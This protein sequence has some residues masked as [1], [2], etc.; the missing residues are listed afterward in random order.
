MASTGFCA[1]LPAQF[2]ID[3][4]HVYQDPEDPIQTL[5]CNPEGFPTAKYIEGN[6][7]NY[8]RMLG[9]IIDSEP[10]KKIVTG[11]SSCSS[12]KDCGNTTGI[13]QSGV[14]KCLPGWTGPKCL[15]PTYC[16][17]FTDWDANVILPPI[18]APFVPNTLLVFVGTLLAAFL[19][20]LYI[21]VASR[22]KL[23]DE[24]ILESP[25]K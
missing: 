16:N 2:L 1:T 20:S 10:L 25:W 3:Y 24:N 11:G 14:C 5:G 23:L 8:V 18:D 9:N 12:A 15:V 7:E 13:C 21:A 22:R 4:V 19:I 6:K 17:N